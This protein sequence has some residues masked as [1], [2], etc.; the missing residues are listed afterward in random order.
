MNLLKTA[1]DR[2][3][4][5]KAEFL[6]MKRAVTECDASFYQMSDGGGTVR[7][8]SQIRDNTFFVWGMSGKGLVS[9]APAIIERVSACGYSAL[10]FV[11]YKPGMRRILRGLGFVEV[12]RVNRSGGT[13]TRHRLMIEG[14]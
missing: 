1:F 3:P 8:V 12:E 11:T 9:V 5:R 2:V 14:N 10:E 4:S 6:E 7:L 13:E